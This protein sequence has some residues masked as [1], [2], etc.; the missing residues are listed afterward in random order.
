M[1]KMSLLTFVHFYPVVQLPDSDTCLLLPYDY[2]CYCLME[3]SQTVHSS[4]LD[5]LPSFL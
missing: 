4:C 3:G 1:L 5:I 2:A